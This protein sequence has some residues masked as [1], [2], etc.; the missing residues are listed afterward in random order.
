MFRI[1]GSSYGLEHRAA[2]IWCETLTFRGYAPMIFS[3][4][5][6]NAGCR[7]VMYIDS[8]QLN[9]YD[10]AMLLAACVQNL[11]L[12]QQPQSPIKK[13]HAVSGSSGG[14]Y[15][16]PSI[17]IVPPVLDFHIVHPHYHNHSGRSQSL[18]AINLI[19]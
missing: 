4:Q 13:E 5:Y 10:F 17:K 8:A 2:D 3:D 14:C 11:L 1:D 6:L 7:S 19:P 18:Q 15:S 9:R 16:N 12:V